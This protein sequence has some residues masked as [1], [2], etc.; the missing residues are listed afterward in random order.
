MTRVVLIGGSGDGRRMEIPKETLLVGRFRVPIELRAEVKALLDGSGLDYGFDT[1][2]VSKIG[3]GVNQ[4]QEVIYYAIHYSLTTCEATH[5]LVVNYHPP[6]EEK[7]DFQIRDLE[8]KLVEEGSKPL[9]EIKTLDV[10]THGS[11]HFKV[12]EVWINLMTSEWLLVDIGE[13]LRHH[14]D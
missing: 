14:G 1:Y 7:V 9:R 3:V 4:E 13:R 5:R 12:G 6:K 10:P 11:L 2:E 8:G